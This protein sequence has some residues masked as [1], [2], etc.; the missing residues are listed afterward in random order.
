M[1]RWPVSERSSGT[2]CGGGLYSRHSAVLHREGKGEVGGGGGSGGG[3]GGG[4]SGVR[5]GDRCSAM[6]IPI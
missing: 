1:T 3:G 5:E 6:Y 2:T 4:G